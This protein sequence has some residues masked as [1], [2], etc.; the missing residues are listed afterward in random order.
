MFVE[1]KGSISVENG[2]DF[3]LV[4]EYSPGVGEALRLAEPVDPE[5]LEFRGAKA[6]GAVNEGTV[7][8]DVRY[9]YSFRALRPGTTEIVFQTGYRGDWKRPE[10]PLA[11][12]IG[13]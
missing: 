2:Q 5:F 3:N 10:P 9:Q 12:T 4:Y 6:L 13:G 7:G 8:G 1:P 11:V